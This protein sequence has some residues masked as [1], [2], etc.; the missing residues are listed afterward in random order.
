MD[1]AELIGEI[2]RLTAEGK[3][4]GNYFWLRRFERRRKQSAAMMLA[5]MQGFRELFDGSNPVKNW[6]V[7]SVWCWQ[8]HCR[9]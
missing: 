5:G 4:I 6:S 7:M 2:R 9:A 8:T 1:V 3:D